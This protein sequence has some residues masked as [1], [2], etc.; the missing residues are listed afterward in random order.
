MKILATVFLLLS[1]LVFSQN[2][3]AVP[4]DYKKI[5]TILDTIDYLYPFLKPDKQYGYW[6]VL[7]NITDPEKSIIYESQMPEYMTI[8]EPAPSKGFF[9]ECE[10][11]GCF[12]YIIAC[13]SDRAQYFTTEQ[14]LRDFIGSVDNI[15]EALLV[16]K[17]YGYSFDSKDKLG[18][19][20]KFENDYILMYL[21]KSQNNP[22]RKES[23]FIKINRKTGKLEAKGNGFYDK[24][25]E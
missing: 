9:Q 15:P 21:S 12:S 25:D 11:E 4:V 22:D 17:T 13:K 3:K 1:G 23:F 2:T 6:K 16:A 7:H 19:S 10:T 18:G 24:S 14:Q 5:P 20:Y 8:N